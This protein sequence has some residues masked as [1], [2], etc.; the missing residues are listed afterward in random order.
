[1]IRA[2]SFMRPHD[3]KNDIKF[4]AQNNMVFSCVIIG[5]LIKFNLTA[6]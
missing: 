6:I 4:I 3:I 2:L 1:M 5:I